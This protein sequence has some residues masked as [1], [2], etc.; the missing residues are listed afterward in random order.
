MIHSHLRLE[1]DE[2]NVLLKFISPV[3][4]RTD[5]LYSACNEIAIRIEENHVKAQSHFWLA[6]ISFRRHD[7]EDI[8][9]FDVL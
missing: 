9:G 8:R 4:S 3:E 2:R 5:F 7:H 6:L 1:T